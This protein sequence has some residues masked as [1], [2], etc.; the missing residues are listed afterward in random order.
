M[1]MR[2]RLWIQYWQR[3]FGFEQ[4]KTGRGQ[5]TGLDVQIKTPVCAGGGKRQRQRL[6]RG[7]ICQHREAHL[8]TLQLGRD[9]APCVAS[10]QPGCGCGRQKGG[11]GGA[12][13]QAR[14]VYSSAQR[15][16][17]DHILLIRRRAKPSAGIWESSFKLRFFLRPELEMWGIRAYFWVYWSTCL[18]INTFEGFFNAGMHILKELACSDKTTENVPP[19]EGV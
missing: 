13:W 17:C 1:Q 4:G 8:L 5:L 3:R 15:P 16:P 10:W 2:H 12:G 18:S 11:R 14:P 7:C 19:M 6:R 9:G